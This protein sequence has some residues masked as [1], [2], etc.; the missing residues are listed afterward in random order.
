MTLS[1]RN[2]FTCRVR[3][4]LPD[5]VQY[6]HVPDV[7]YVERFLQAHYQPLGKGRNRK[8]KIKTQHSACSPVLTASWI[9]RL[10]VPSGTPGG[11]DARGTEDVGRDR[12]ALFLIYHSCDIQ[13][14][15][16]LLP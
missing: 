4:G 3:R 8:S 7:V 13:S 9:R 6:L 12:A 10:P 14:Q 11:L 5:C 2:L 16:C 15:Q 1:S